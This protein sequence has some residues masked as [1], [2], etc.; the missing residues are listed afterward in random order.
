MISRGGKIRG[1]FYLTSV[2]HLYMNHVYIQ[3][4]CFF[5]ENLKT[6]GTYTPTLVPVSYKICIKS[7]VLLSQYH[8]TE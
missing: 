1:G 6:L 5:P 7:L 8:N 4:D 3:M 2:L